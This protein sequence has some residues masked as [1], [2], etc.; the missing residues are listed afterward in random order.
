MRMWT[1]VYYL[2]EA[3]GGGQREWPEWNLTR[4]SSEAF[5]VLGG[6]GWWGE[7]M[8]EIINLAG[9]RNIN[10]WDM[11]YGLRRPRISSPLPPSCPVVEIYY[12]WSID[13][14]AHQGRGWRGNVLQMAVV[15]IDARWA[16]PQRS[17]VTPYWDKR[18]FLDAKTICLS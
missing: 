16:L 4:P 15:I 7:W 1:L 10:S 18:V 6:W 5:T 3:S 9:W 8:A 17:P 13:V 11:N 12:D 2:F 14:D